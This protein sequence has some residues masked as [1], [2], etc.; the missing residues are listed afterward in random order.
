MRR[1]V[2]EVA[3]LSILAAVPT[4][5]GYVLGPLSRAL[6]ATARAF[7][8]PVAPRLGFIPLVTV[9]VL[10]RAYLGRGAAVKEGVLLAL[11]G[12]VFHPRDLSLRVLRNIMLGVGVELG[13]I[14]V[15]RI[16][17]WSC[18]LAGLVGG[19]L[20]Y[21]PYLLFAPLSVG[22]A[23]LYAAL[24]LSSVNWLLS[25]AIGGYL[26]SIVFRRSEWITV[27]VAHLTN[28]LS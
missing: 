14:G 22:A 25:C 12:A 15:K 26:A 13:M 5:L 19:A 16:D 11:L 9:T 1:A 10:A 8:F 28:R 2:V 18:V 7:G 17:A 20:S 27:G 3:V 4:A 21:T 23:V 6:S 24:I